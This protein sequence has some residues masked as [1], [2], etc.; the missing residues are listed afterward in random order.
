MTA[1]IYVQLA[2]LSLI[3]TTIA[4]V[5]FKTQTIPDLANALLA[6]SGVIVQ[7]HSA[8]AVWIATN[9]L[10]YF[11][12]FWLVRSAHTLVTGRVG[13]GFGDVKMAGA[14]GAWLSLGLFPFFI[15]AAAF[16]ALFAVAGAGLVKG[17]SILL[18]R[19]PF[20]PFLALSLVACWILQVSQIDL[21]ELYGF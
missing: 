2:V 13:L 17:R 14:A 9:I 11:G 8:S 4:V 6:V 5:D 18:Q 12:I 16:A 21:V 3:A 10:G 20:G 15:G 19:I 7:I 1:L